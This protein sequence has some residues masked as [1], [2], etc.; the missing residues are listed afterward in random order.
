MFKSFF[1]SLRKRWTKLWEK[2][3][4]IQKQNKRKRTSIAKR[5]N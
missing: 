5:K 2:E 1:Q 4:K 3:K